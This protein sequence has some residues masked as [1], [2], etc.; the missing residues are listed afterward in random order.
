MKGARFHQVPPLPLH[1]EKEEQTEEK[2]EEDRGGGEA[3]EKESG[4]E[5]GEDWGSLPLSD[6][7]QHPL[8]ALQGS[9]HQKRSSLRAS[10]P[11]VAAYP[12]TM[13]R[14]S[15]GVNAVR[16]P[17]LPSRSFSARREQRGRA[18]SRAPR[19]QTVPLSRGCYPTSPAVHLRRPRHDDE[20][21]RSPSLNE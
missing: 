2:K 14:A 21:S 1:M 8:A 10:Y 9:S 18:A 5:D 13:T 19:W 4:K 11:A 7:A 17:S 20:R 6:P 12:Q 3:Q 16:L 15:A